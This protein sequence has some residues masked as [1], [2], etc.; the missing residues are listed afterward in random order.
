MPPLQHAP[1]STVFNALFSLMQTVPA[2]SIPGATVWKT[3]SQHLILWD[4]VPAVNQPA[5]FLHRGPQIADQKHVFGIT[6]PMWRASIWVYFRT[7]SF[8]TSSTYPDQITDRLLDSFEET[9][10]TDPLIRR[11]TLGTYTNAQGRTADIAYH[12]WI[13]G[14]TYFDV[15]VVDS[16]AVIVIPISILV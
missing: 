13:D 8:N 6:R 3:V 5:M 12:C 16:Q 7:D 9:F 11:Q 1:R 2:T 10:Q 14:T 4:Q 15:G